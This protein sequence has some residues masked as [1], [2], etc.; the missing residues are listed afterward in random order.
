MYFL[1]VIV[2][3]LGYYV[4]V[5]AF[6]LNKNEDE[7]LTANLLR[8]VVDRINKDYS[9]N[10]ADVERNGFTIRTRLSPMKE[11]DDEPNY[12][13]MMDDENIIPSLRDTEYL[14]HGPLWGHQF[15]TGG[16]GEGK[17]NLKPEGSVSNKNEVKT[18][19]VLPAYCNP[20]NPCPVGFSAEAGCIQQFENTAAFSREYQAA[21]K[22][23]CDSEHMFDCPSSHEF[24]YDNDL[25]F[26]QIVNR[27][28]ITNPFLQGEMLPIAAKKGINIGY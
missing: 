5:N 10:Y 27:Y 25:D 1:Y 19:A 15:M 21:Q 26:E 22:C 12:S 3:S 2:Y 7:F 28:K 14:Q 13:E 4:Y 16:A 9:N 8:A 20:P 23:M 6:Q 18:D 17:Q 11:E 24:S